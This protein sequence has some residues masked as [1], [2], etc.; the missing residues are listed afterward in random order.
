MEPWK[1]N[2]EP[3][4]LTQNCTGWLWKAQV[5]TGDSKE[6]VIIFRDKHTLHHNI[7]I[8][9]FTINACHDHTLLVHLCSLLLE[10]LIIIIIIIITNFII[11][12]TLFV[13]ITRCLFTC[14]PCCWIPRASHTRCR[15]RWRGS[16]TPS[17]LGHRQGGAPCSR[18]QN[19]Y[20][21]KHLVVE[22]F[23]WH[24]WIPYQSEYIFL[25]SIWINWRRGY[26]TQK[27]SLPF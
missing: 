14:A 12:I 19:E 22:N 9:I 10:S 1:T 18:F 8:I 2:L 25:L 3:S 11:M 5:V 24:P 15:S 27:C 26:W 20:S 21:P 13:M 6:E 23:W 7:Y 17:P 4:K 16:R